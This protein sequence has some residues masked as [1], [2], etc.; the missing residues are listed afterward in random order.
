[1][2]AGA[3]RAGAPA[4]PVQL[5][6]VSLVDLAVV[7]MGGYVVLIV[8]AGLLM[9]LRP[10]L[11]Q[12]AVYPPTDEDRIR[13][14]QLQG[15]MPKKAWGFVPPVRHSHY[16]PAPWLNEPPQSDDDSLENVDRATGIKRELGSE[17]PPWD[18]LDRQGL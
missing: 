15:A 11:G 5:G 12:A 16:E 17:H 18:R 4:V 9:A 6:D 8:L 14:R 7:F 1:M 10:G 3:E 2:R 13:L